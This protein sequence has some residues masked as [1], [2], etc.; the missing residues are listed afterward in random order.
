MAICSVA[1]ASVGLILVSA[2]GTQSGSSSKSIRII[3]TNDTIGYLEPCG[4]GGRYQGGLARRATV[5][6]RLV[7]ENPNSL[8]VESG[9]LSDKASKL[10]LVAK[11]MADMHYDAVGIGEVD[12]GFADDFFKATSK[13][14]LKVVDATVVDGSSVV[15]YLVRK[16]GGVKI[17]VVSFGKTANGVGVKQLDNLRQSFRDAYER[18]RRQSD[19]LVL[20]DQGGIATKEWLK[21]EAVQIGAPDI[22]IG[23]ILNSVMPREQVI[24]R[25]H[26]VP[27]SVQGKLVG[28]ID[29]SLIRG[30]L[31][32][33]TLK[34]V[35]VDKSIPEDEAVRKQIGD[36]LTKP[37]PALSMSL[38]FRTPQARKVR[39]YYDPESCKACH[40]NEYED[41]RKTNHAKALQTLR[42]KDRLIPEC[43]QCHSEEFRQT[44]KYTAAP[45]IHAGVE[46]AT[47]HA[48]VLP[49]GIE[50]PASTVTHKVD[51]K[52]CLGCHTSERSPDYDE[53][54]YLPTV[55][56]KSKR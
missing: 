44:G 48:T 12:A 2:A 43:L 17:G 20:L 13:C 41:W 49:H 56:H 51:A 5:I 9:N 4:C 42:S 47:C 26:I 38:N 45:A 34:M 55:S 29:V 30:Q 3:Y 1:L 23:G 18:A 21:G 35:P 33:P 16:I 37:Q 25:T 24:G 39:S 10:P 40:P 22:V 28:V 15:P 31:P 7:K 11:L 36:F 46:C 52:I 19:I 32:P 53:K 6:A 8:I 50:G 54:T 14:G 27:T